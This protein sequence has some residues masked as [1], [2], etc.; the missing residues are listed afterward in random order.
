LHG[1]NAEGIFIPAKAKKVV[2]KGKAE[3]YKITL[4]DGTILKSTGNHR[5]V[6]NMQKLVYT[7]NLN[8]GDGIYA[9]NTTFGVK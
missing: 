7:E 9:L 3:V 5:W 6:N 4:E 8:V 1:L 2:Y